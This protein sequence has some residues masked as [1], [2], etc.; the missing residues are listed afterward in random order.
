MKAAVHA[1]ETL[2]D[3]VAQ[4]EMPL[5]MDQLADNM[6]Q[7]RMQDERVSQP[8]VPEED[9]SVELAALDAAIQEEERQALMSRMPVVPSHEPVSAVPAAAAP[10]ASASSKV[11]EP[12]TQ[13][14]GQRTLL[15]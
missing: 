15:A 11:D 7:L 13:S 12:S 4:L 6:A 2:N 9:V 8:L 1:L 5:V 10:A 14:Q 3:R